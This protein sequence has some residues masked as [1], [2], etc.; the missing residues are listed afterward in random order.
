M[1]TKDVALKT[2]LSERRVQQ[3]A[4]LYA[5]KNGRDWYWTEAGVKK[6]IERKGKTGRQK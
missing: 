6:L 4:H 5:E 1:T 3:A 2:G